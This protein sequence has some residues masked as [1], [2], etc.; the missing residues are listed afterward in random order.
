MAGEYRIVRPLGTGGFGTVFEAE[1]PVLKRKAAV[2]VLHE[3]RSVDASA[4][5]RFVAEAQSANQIKHR[6]IVDIFS[7]GTLKGGRHFYVMEPRSIATCTN[8]SGCRRRSRCRSSP[9][10]PTRSMPCTRWASSIVT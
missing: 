4:V 2:K 6:H 3:S 7:F 9:R 8:E 10:S 5:L 1:H